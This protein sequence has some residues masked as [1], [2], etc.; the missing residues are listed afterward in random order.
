MPLTAA[1]LSIMFDS[2]T[3]TVL[4][5]NMHNR[6]TYVN[7]AG[8]GLLGKSEE[9]ICRRTPE[10]SAPELVPLLEETHGRAIQV[11]VNGKEMIGCSEMVRDHAG[12]TGRL[13]FLKSLNHFD[14]ILRDL[15][16]AQQEMQMIFDASFDEIFIT[17]SGG[18]C[19][20][21]SAN[22]C[23]RL[24]GVEPEEF[25]GM[26]VKDL[27]AAGY[28]R[29]S[30]LP[31]IAKTK[32]RVT[33]LQDTKMGHKVVVTSNPILDEEGNVIRIVTNSREV[34]EL[35]YPREQFHASEERMK[36]HYE[37]I[38]E[39][40]QDTGSVEWLL[41][42]SPAMRTVMELVRKAAQFDTTILI[43]G[44]SG[45]G[46]DLVARAVHSLSSRSKGPY[47]KINCGAIPDSLLE[48]E[49]FGYT[50]GAFTGANKE[51]KIG[52]LE[53]A[54]EG[55]VYLDEIGELPLHLQAKLLQA[56]EEKVI[57]RVGAYKPKQID[58]RIVAATN[59]DLDKMVEEGRFRHDL[60]F[61]LNV[62]NIVIPPLRERPEDI[63]AL[64][65]HFVKRFN[66]SFRTEKSISNEAMEAFLAYRWPGNVRE[67]EN[68]LERFMVLYEDR[69]LKPEH[70]PGEFHGESAAK[71]NHRARSSLI[72]LRKAVEETER[73]MLLEAFGK[74]TSTFQ[75][76]EAL[77]LSH[78]TL[79]R[80]MKKYRITP[81]H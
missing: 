30:H 7:P 3:S 51:G 57:F 19:L 53:T 31:Q 15:K 32:N 27:E 60:F 29:P 25:V 44:E 79:L 78:S 20:K 48:S 69:E 75:V 43:L 63:R 24:Y 72:P 64:A 12:G 46:K 21:V 73:Q 34:T 37:H 74:Y 40:K 22:A 10:H 55:T 49:L 50:R 36:K 77:Q 16:V 62:I 8:L 80:R 38:L 71:P 17:D 68:L 54:G 39:L 2:F 58:V 11:R 35:T 33:S 42:E 45:V 6:V 1:V 56:I 81:G 13:L 66:S 4:Y 61:R 23:R 76:A 28:F 67:L 18:K 70:L 14:G 5:V 52:L 47:V 41:D 65:E 26:H 59:R 9:E